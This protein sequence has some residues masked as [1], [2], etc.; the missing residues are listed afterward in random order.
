MCH[1]ILINGSYWPQHTCLCHQH[2]RMQLWHLNWH[3]STLY[4]KQCLTGISVLFIPISNGS[5]YIWTCGLWENIFCEDHETGQWQFG[6][7]FT[8]T[9]LLIRKIDVHC[10]HRAILYRRHFYLK[11][12]IYGE[13]SIDRIWYRGRFYDK[14]YSSRSPCSHFVKVP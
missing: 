8:F 1:Q 5:L 6:I 9:G 2:I 3:I 14:H 4:S 13:D 12:P 10:G 7:N 11:P